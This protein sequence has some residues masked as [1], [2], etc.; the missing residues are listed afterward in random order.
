MKIAIG[1]LVLALQATF[2][3]AQAG[4]P[5]LVQKHALAKVAS[6]VSAPVAHPK[7]TLK[8]TFGVTVFAV[9]NVVDGARVGLTVADKVFDVIS[10]SGKIPALDVIYA[11]VSIGAKDAARLDMWL[12]RQEGFLFGM[13]N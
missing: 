5:Q 12:E 6:I 9:E 3:F 10:L 7:R 2:G 13:H 4:P 1:V 8:E 11:G